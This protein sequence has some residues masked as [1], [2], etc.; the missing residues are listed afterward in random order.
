MQEIVE[1]LLFMLIVVFLYKFSNRTKVSEEIVYVLYKRFA[2]SFPQVMKS[3]T[4]FKLGKRFLL[5]NQIQLQLEMTAVLLTCY[6][7]IHLYI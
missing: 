1:I 6:H 7:M 4:D 3:D 5:M 2:F